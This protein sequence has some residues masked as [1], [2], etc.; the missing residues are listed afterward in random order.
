MTRMR[1]ILKMLMVIIL[2]I[3]ILIFILVM[4]ILETTRRNKYDEQIALGDKYLAEQDYDQAEL[5]FK[6]AINISDK[7]AEP[8]IKLANVYRETGDFDEAV[9]IVQSGT[10]SDQGMTDQQKEILESYASE[11]QAVAKADTKNTNTN[12]ASKSGNKIVADVKAN[13]GSEDIVDDEDYGND[14]E[15]DMGDEEPEPDNI[16]ASTDSGEDNVGQG[17]DSDNENPDDNKDND[18]QR[19]TGQDDI[20]KGNKIRSQSDLRKIVQDTTGLSYIGDM[21]YGITAAGSGEQILCDSMGVRGYLAAHEMDYDGDGAEEILVISLQN[22]EIHSVKQDAFC[23]YM[24]KQNGGSWKIQDAY[25]IGGERIGDIDELSTVLKSDI[26]PSRVQF[27]AMETDEGLDIVMEMTAKAGIFSSKEPLG[28]Q[29]YTYS[30]GGF[31]YGE[32]GFWVDNLS[33]VVNQTEIMQNLKTWGFS[34]DRL[35]YG[36]EVMGQ[37]VSAIP[38]ARI[39]RVSLMP[40]ITFSGWDRISPL[41][42]IGRVVF[43]DYSEAKAVN[44]V[45]PE[46]INLMDIPLGISAEDFYNTWEPRL[47][48]M[49]AIQ[50]QSGDDREEYLLMKEA[51]YPDIPLNA[52][53]IFRDSRLICVIITNA[54]FGIESYEQRLAAGDGGLVDKCVRRFADQPDAQIFKGTLY[55]WNAASESAELVRDLESVRFCRWDNTVWSYSLIQE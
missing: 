31:T 24:L 2:L 6:R 23:M 54:D 41:E 47:E 1:K 36:N 18:T 30:D 46:T 17:D 4:L 9:A 14:G 38:L 40:E 50:T 3:L 49:Q 7:I 5:C 42:N 10:N 12:K 55:H 21:G 33:E 53:F 15:P 45:A 19:G 28:I 52:G 11:I 22:E 35:G 8:Y 43:T 44:N 25:V 16:E 29:R 13:G 32:I 51:S 34:V 27:F 37:T 26:F 39:D 20:D 48:A